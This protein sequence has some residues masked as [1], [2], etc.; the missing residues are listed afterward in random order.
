MQES[1]VMHTI[2]YFNAGAG[3]IMR[4]RGGEIL[5]YYHLAFL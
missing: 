2:L 1:I 3:D 5:R 4:G